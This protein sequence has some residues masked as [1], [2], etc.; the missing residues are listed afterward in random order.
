MKTNRTHL[1]F[2]LLMMAA[3]V[4]LSGCATIPQQEIGNDPRFSAA[5]PM[6]PAVAEAAK[7]TI[8]N[9][10]A[11]GF[12]ISDNKA[13]Q[14]G[15]ILTVVL[16]E[17]T[18]A[19]KSTNASSSRDANMSLLDP[20]IAGGTITSDGVP[21]LNN[22]IQSS[23]GFSGEGEAG[24]SNLLEGSVTVTVAGVYPNGNL[25]VQGEKWIRINRGQE[26]I[27]LRGIV[28]PVDISADNSVLSTQ[29]GNAEIAYGGTGQ[30][31]RSTSQGWLSRFFGSVIW[32][33]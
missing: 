7:G 1:N 28:R 25:M 33:L 3:I 13:R 23:Q 12:L 32:P 2:M 27:Q 17:E 20:I 8:F 10:A 5:F 4:V 21:I 24:Q 15:D 18:N 31:A 22:E 11:A 30:I 9:Q 19:Q 26:Y 14:V 29:V 16:A 6:P